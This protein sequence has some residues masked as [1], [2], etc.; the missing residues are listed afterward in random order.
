MVK[1]LAA[2]SAPLLGD[3]ADPVRA[4]IF[5]ALVAAFSAAG[6]ALILR[7]H[8]DRR[9]I[10][11]GAFYL[12]I[13]SAFADSLLHSLTA[14][15]PRVMGGIASL[16]SFQLAA[17]QPFFFWQFVRDFPRRLGRHGAQYLAR[18][19]AMA[20]LAIGFILLVA[21]VVRPLARDPALRASLAFLD[22]NDAGSSF[23]LIVLLFAFPV[24]PY[25]A[26]KARRARLDERRRAS[27]LML[28]IGVGIAPIVLLSVAEILNPTFA[29][30]NQLPGRRLIMGLIAYPPL[31]SVPLTTAYAIIVHKALDVRLII[32]RALRYALV[33]S[34]LLLA[35]A[36]PFA[37]IL[38]IVYSRRHETLETVLRG[39][40]GV[41][42]IVMA[43]LGLA[44]A[45]LRPRLLSS[46]DRRFFREQYDA[47]AMLAL[48]VD[49]ARTVEE[50]AE[51]AAVIPAEIAR[52]LHLTSASMLLLDPLAGVLATP[53]RTVRPLSV[54]SR[55]AADLAA[56]DQYLEVD[57]TIAPPWMDGLPEEDR[58]WLIEADARLLIPIRARADTLLGV[59]VLGEK[60]SDLP[61]TKEDQLV[62]RTVAQA[63]ALSVEIR[64]L[65]SRTLGAT[66][67]ELQTPAAECG[68]CGL[69]H[70]ASTRLCRRCGAPLGPS[71]VPTL[72]AG[73]FEPIERIGRGGM[74]VVYRTFDMALTRQ[75]ALKTLPKTGS[76]GA[77]RMRHEAR[78]MAAVSHPN[79]EAIYAVESWC[80]TPMLIVELLGGGTL[81]DRLRGG[82][83]DPASALDIASSIGDALICLHQA[84]M[85]HRDIK[86]GNIGFSTDGTPKLLDFGLAWMLEA[87][88]DGA[89]PVSRLA[90]TLVSADV[91]TLGFTGAG[92]IVGTIPYLS[93]EMIDGQPLAPAV[94][95]W[96]LSMVLYEAIAGTHPFMGGSAQQVMNRILTTDVP[97]IRLK[98]SEVPAPVALFLLQCLSRDATRRP[99]SA[100]DWKRQLEGTRALAGGMLRRA[101]A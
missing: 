54:T 100:R 76:A 75:V 14:V 98:R 24:L 7:G 99:R 38:V 2:M 52:A 4:T 35:I 42:L 80:G 46:L 73:K 60:Q 27:I 86:P 33:R 58:Q 50:P 56:R 90:A 65:H 34:T 29:A 3:L 67:E 88:S 95:L 21:N 19:C 37:L 63:V 62:L 74:G 85:L 49:R 13:G 79:L 70:D 16:T 53:V 45:V 30:L 81:G 59:L 26:W 66:R 91:Q 69:L 20:A 32:R 39:R 55:L 89:P 72:L 94:D 93:P 83:L 96:A 43:A 11:L 41:V 9:A 8:R 71:L 36:T 84:G 10:A 68:A 5:W 23:W 6:L 97:D 25:M 51:I 22:R 47:H 77:A 17:F 64:L 28:G 44:A 1:A 78:A 57:W 12:V 31:L 101:I 61:F 18:A 48:L 87:G 40:L 82:P 92:E 15:Q